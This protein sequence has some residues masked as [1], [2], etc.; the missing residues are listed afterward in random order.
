MRGPSPV[1]L[2]FVLALFLIPAGA[3]QDPGS[4]YLTATE[5]T[6]PGGDLPQCSANAYTL[7]TAVPADGKAYQGSSSP[8]LACST[9][10]VHTVVEPFTLSGEATAHFFV[11]CDSP[12]V[13]GTPVTVAW[14]VQLRKNGETL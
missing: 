5:G 3:A 7:E 13:V 2:G 14:R 9:Y 1:A 10:F 12:V 8:A 4:I 11:S 6:G